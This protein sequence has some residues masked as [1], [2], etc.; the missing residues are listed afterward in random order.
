MQRFHADKF[1]EVLNLLNTVESL[2]GNQRPFVTQQET[3]AFVATQVD[4]LHQ[5]LLELDLRVSARMANRVLF[6]LRGSSSD[7]AQA[8]DLLLKKQ[9]EELRERVADELEGKVIYYISDHVDMLTTSPLFGEEVDEAFSSARYDISEAGLCLAFVRSTACVLHLMRA[10][11]V[12]LK[13]LAMELNLNPTKETWKV[14]IDQ[15]EKQIRSGSRANNGDRWN[16]DDEQFFAES[17]TH[18]LLIKDAWRNYATHG[19]STYTAEK[20]EDIY[21]S[22]RSFMR[23]LSNR[24]SENDLAT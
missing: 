2:L 7:N 22:V 8:R 9:S 19:K 10:V 11:E 15:I 14:L 18:F 13:V 5:Q 4:L 20:A 1:V 24:L 6:S 21:R 3:L 16:S 23:H 12:A 17:A